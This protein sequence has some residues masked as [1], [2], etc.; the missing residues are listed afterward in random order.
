MQY[1]SKTD[2]KMDDSCIIKISNEIINTSQL[3]WMDSTKRIIGSLFNSRNTSKTKLRENPLR[4]K[5]KSYLLI[6][7]HTFSS[8]AMFSSSFQC[9]HVGNI[10]G[11]ETGGLT[12]CFGDVYS[13]NLPNTKFDMGVSY[14]KF[15]NACGVDNRRGVIPDYTVENSFEDE[16][17]EIDKVLEFTFDLMKQEK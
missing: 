3:N 12:T 9:Y 5:G 4:F 13:F 1:I 6:S 17:K 16:R 11:T 14:K 15:Y 2:F 10:I 8:A 7:G